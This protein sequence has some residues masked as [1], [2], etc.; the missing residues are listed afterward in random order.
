[1]LIKRI[2]GAAGALLLAVVSL[3]AMPVYADCPNKPITCEY[4]AIG[5]QGTCWHA[6]KVRCESCGP[7][8]CP[9]SPA[10]SYTQ[11]P[12]RTQFACVAKIVE[13]KQPDGCSNSLYD[14]LTKEYKKLFKPA[15]DQH[16]ICY[17]NNIGAS[18]GHCDNEFKANMDHMCSRLYP[19]VANVA[20]LGSCKAGSLTWYKFLQIAP[21]ARQAFDD[22]QKWTR[23]NCGK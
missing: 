15:C 14:P 12:H 16:D 5:Y 1:M 21:Q 2:V 23:A 13:T 8:H 4:G 7:Q 18:K 22:D 19:G 17:R 6:S 11:M 9:Q 3:I 10:T 20:Q